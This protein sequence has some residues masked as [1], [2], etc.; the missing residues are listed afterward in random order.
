ML[1]P[2]V[3]FTS[4]PENITKI[5]HDIGKCFERKLN[6]FNAG[7][8]STSLILLN[9]QIELDLLLKLFPIHVSGGRS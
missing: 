9:A 5:I 4:I 1:I 2:G 3:P 7:H 8:N 6:D